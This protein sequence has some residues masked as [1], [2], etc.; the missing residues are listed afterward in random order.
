MKLRDVRANPDGDVY[1]RTG[2]KG[3]W[4]KMSEEYHIPCEIVPAE[5]GDGNVIR[6]AGSAERLNPD[7]EVEA[8]QRE[9]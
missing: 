9:P 6:G 3:L 7:E 4:Y 1:K 2:F 8:F 5:Y